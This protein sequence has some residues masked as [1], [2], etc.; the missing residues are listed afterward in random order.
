MPWQL[1][2]QQHG[3]LLLEEN[4]SETGVESADTLVLQH[5]AETTDKAVGIGGLGDETDTGGLKWAEGD[6]GEELS[7]SG[8]G[9]VD[10]SAVLGSGLEAL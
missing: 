6:I 5:L 3:D 7:E 8:G 10:S 2:H 4:G 1:Q 9:E